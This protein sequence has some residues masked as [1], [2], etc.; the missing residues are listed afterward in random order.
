M[1]RW[2]NFLAGFS[3]QI[4]HVGSRENIA[5]FPS[6]FPHESWKLWKE[7]DSYLNFRN[8]G[9]L[10]IINCDVLREETDK[11]PELRAVREWLRTGKRN[12]NVVNGAFKKISAELSV[13]NGLVM[14]GVRVVVPVKLRRNVLYQVHRSHLGIVKSK[15]VLRSFVWWPS[16]DAELEVHVKNCSEC[17]I[18]QPSPEKAKLIP[19]QPPQSVW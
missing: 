6:R 5:D 2:A 14:R 3:Y 16:I 13:E 17:L 4:E 10:A 8:F 19:W 11:D 1:Q 7:D 9:D 12:N 15:S 18:G